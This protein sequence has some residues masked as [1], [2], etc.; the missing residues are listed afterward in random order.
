[1]LLLA[2]ALQPTTAQAVDQPPTITSPD[3]AWFAC[4]GEPQAFLVTTTGN[5]VPTS[6]LTGELPEWLYFFDQGDGT[7]LLAVDVYFCGVGGIYP[8]TFT[9]SNGIAPDAVQTF[10]LT[11]YTPPYSPARDRPRSLLARSV[12]LP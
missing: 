3:A 4:N 2:L 1:L 10:S 11:Y 5:P 7:G 6:S 9:A 12:R 8:L